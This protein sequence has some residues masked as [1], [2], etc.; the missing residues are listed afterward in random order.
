MLLSYAPPVV[1]VSPVGVSRAGGIPGALWTSASGPGRTAPALQ[2]LPRP[3]AQSHV[4][5][6]KM[7]TRW[8]GG[9]GV[10]LCPIN[11]I[12]RRFLSD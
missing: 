6:E 2:R 11:F 1:A 8:D 4:A 10:V 7:S 12:G 5:A 3:A 9:G